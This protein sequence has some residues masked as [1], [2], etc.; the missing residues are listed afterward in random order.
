MWTDKIQNVYSSYEEFVAYDEI[1]L[2]SS[3]L[4]FTDREEL[5]ETNPMISGSTNPHDLRIVK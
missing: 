3:R 1:Y 5:W 2:I 4:G